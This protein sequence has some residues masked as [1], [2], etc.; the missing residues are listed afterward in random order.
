MTQVG[1]QPARKHTASS[2]QVLFY[3]DEQLRSTL[4]CIRYGACMN[5]CPVY[6]RIGSHAYGITYPGPIG[7]IISPHMLGLAAT[8]GRADSAAAPAST[9]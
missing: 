9:S 7:E 2:R 1:Q 4:Q 5:H 3:S 8:H 6:T